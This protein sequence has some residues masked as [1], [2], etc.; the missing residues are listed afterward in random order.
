MKCRK[1][2]E[3]RSGVALNIREH[4]ARFDVS[5]EDNFYIIANEI[6]KSESDYDPDDDL[7]EEL[8]EDLL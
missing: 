2:E 1:N 7:L 3:P 4:F 5:T 6:R 8:L